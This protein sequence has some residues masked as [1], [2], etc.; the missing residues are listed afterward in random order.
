MTTYVSMLRGINVGGNKRIA[1]AE[2]V[3]L[4]EALGFEAARTYIQS[5]NVIFAS[6]NPDAQ[7]VRKA[8]EDKIRASLG[9]SVAVVI[10]TSEELERIIAG[11]Q[12]AARGMDAGKLHVTFLADAPVSPLLVPGETSGEGA[13]EFYLSGRE[14]YLFCPN[15]YGRTKLSNSFFER[16][17]GVLATTRNWKTVNTLLALARQQS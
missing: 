17:L 4:Y 10:R 1:M 13:D 6:T 8:L 5:G 7:G 3:S 16:K 9:I 12:F 14:I 2:L 11:N 15:G